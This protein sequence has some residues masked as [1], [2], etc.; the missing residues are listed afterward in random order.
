[1]SNQFHQ[2][3]EDL[4]FLYI[5]TGNAEI[6]EKFIKVSQVYESALSTWLSK[7][8]RDAV[9]DPNVAGAL[10]ALADL[11]EKYPQGMG[12]SEVAREFTASKLTKYLSYIMSFNSLLRDEDVSAILA[13]Y[14]DIIVATAPLVGGLQGE[15]IDV[16]PIKESLMQI[17]QG[18]LTYVEQQESKEWGR[19][20]TA[21]EK[22]IEMFSAL[23][24]RFSSEL[25]AAASNAEMPGLAA[26]V[27]SGGLVDHSMIKQFVDFGPFTQFIGKNSKKLVDYVN[28]HYDKKYIEPN[29]EYL[30]HA[31]LDFAGAIDDQALQQYYVEVEEARRKDLQQYMDPD[32]DVEEMGAPAANLPSLSVN[33][34]TWLNP[35]VI[36][37]LAAF[38]VLYHHNLFS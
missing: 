30:K 14:R 29:F 25:S 37:G 38:F 5:R 18:F 11:K 26:A 21:K 27:N 4:K 3:S 36:R 31:I 33:D 19:K 35:L 22:K 7:G 15:P 6:E 20:K 2:L 1:M 23:L 8:K 17:Q 10:Q 24:Q 13:P 32:F 34:R 9:E 12:L 16:A 28:K